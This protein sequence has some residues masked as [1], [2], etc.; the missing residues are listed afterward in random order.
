MTTRHRLEFFLKK[1]TLWSTA[2]RS[3]IARKERKLEFFFI[4]R[5]FRDLLDIATDISSC[6]CHLSG[7]TISLNNIIQLCFVYFYHQQR[8][9]AAK[10]G[11][12]ICGESGKRPTKYQL[13]T[14]CLFKSRWTLC[15]YLTLIYYLYMF[16]IADER[17]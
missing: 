6:F 8:R 5:D 9:Q 7:A 12:N 4:Q 13:S 10:K 3:V 1:G 14:L 11:T 17:S 15:K 16:T 2:T